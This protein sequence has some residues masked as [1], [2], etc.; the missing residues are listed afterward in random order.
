MRAS[1]LTWEQAHYAGEEGADWLMSKMSRDFLSKNRSGPI[2]GDISR[3]LKFG[4]CRDIFER[5]QYK[6]T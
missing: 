3:E 6:M 2:Q 4:R 1:Q 5:P